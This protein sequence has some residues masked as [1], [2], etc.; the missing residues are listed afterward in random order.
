MEVLGKEVNLNRQT[1]YADRVCLVSYLDGLELI[2][3]CN[4]DNLVPIFIWNSKVKLKRAWGLSFKY[5]KQK[6]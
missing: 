3:I 4:S 1:F 5:D 6:T 2:N